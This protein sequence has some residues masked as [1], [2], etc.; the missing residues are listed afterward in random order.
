M[1]QLL[2]KKK[3]VHDDP[4]N[5]QPILRPILWKQSQG[6]GGKSFVKDIRRVLPD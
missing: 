1:N 3:L 2:S 6:H 5:Y 4:E